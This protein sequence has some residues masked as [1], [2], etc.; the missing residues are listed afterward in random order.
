M[1]V[2][3]IGDLHL[4]AEQKPMDVFGPHWIDHFQRI[5]GDWRSRVS[6]SDVVLI[7]GDISWAMQLDEA[8]PDLNAIGALPGRKILTR[9]NHDYW[10]NS[11]SRV[12]DALPQNMYALQNDALA[13][14][15]VLFAGTR[16]WTLAMDDAAEAEDRRI[17]QREQIRLE[18]SL[19]AARRISTD[20]PLVAMIHFPPLTPSCPDT[21]FSELFQRYRAD[22]VVYGHLHGP[23]LRGA[24]QGVRDGVMYHLVSCDGLGFQLHEVMRVDDGAL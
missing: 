6:E 18:M 16:G 10:W 2:F 15:G 1:T 4:P 12:R 22:H 23:A 7:P 14:A 5:A 13:L 11:I 19:K 20:M 21:P 8:K 17:F 3:A 24:F 9:G